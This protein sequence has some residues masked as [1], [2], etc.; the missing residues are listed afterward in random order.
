VDIRHL[1]HR[2]LTTILIILKYL[3]GV[4][5]STFTEPVSGNE[6]SYKTA[7]LLSGHQ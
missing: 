3:S 5:V 4:T 6:T 2:G 1:L 7:V